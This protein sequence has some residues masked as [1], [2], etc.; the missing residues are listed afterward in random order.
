[1]RVANLLEPSL[2]VEVKTSDK[3]MDAPL[4]TIS[5]SGPKA[6]VSYTPNSSNS[7]GL[8]AA[9][10]NRNPF[11]IKYG[12]FAA[13]YGATKEQKAALD[14]GS[15]ATF[16]SPETGMRAAK[17]LLL[18]KNYR[19]LTVDQAMR[20]WSNNG[21]GGNIF[22]ELADRK[23]SD[24]SDAELTALQ[25]KQLIREDG[26]YARKLGY[27]AFGGPL[28]RIPKY[29]WGSYLSGLEAKSPGMLAMVGGLAGEGVDMIGDQQKIVAGRDAA[30]GALKGAGSGAALGTMLLPGIGTAVG[31]IAGAG[32]G[33]ASSLIKAKQKQKALAKSL[34]SEQ[35]LFSSMQE[36]G[37]SSAYAQLQPLRQYKYGGGFTPEYEVEKGEVVQGDAT[38]SNSK[39]LATELHEVTGYTHDQKNPKTGTTG[40]LGAGGDRA[41][42]NRLPT[43][44]GETFAE[45]AKKFS[46]YIRTGEKK[47]LSKNPLEKRTGQIILQKANQALDNLFEEQ[48]AMK[49]PTYAYGGTLPKLAKGGELEEKNKKLNELL[50][51][52]KL[53]TTP[54]AKAAVQSEIDSILSNEADL[55]PL[56]LPKTKTGATLD[57]NNTKKPKVG[58][59]VGGS[60]GIAL[61]RG[62]KDHPLKTV[63]DANTDNPKI[64]LPGNLPKVNLPTGTRDHELSLVEDDPEGLPKINLP[65][66]GKTATGGSKPTTN[67]AP[68]KKKEEVVS[69]VPDKAF[70]DLKRQEAEFAASKTPIAA[71]GNR[72]ATANKLKTQLDAR[73]TAIGVTPT[74]ATTAATTGN[75]FKFGDNALPIGLSAL[76]YLNTQKAINRSKTQVAANVT[77]APFYGYRDNSNLGRYNIDSA[78]NT[79]TQSRNVSDAQK[80]GYFAS[81]L[82]A[83]NQVN[84]GE[85]ERKM[86]YDINY[87][88]NKLRT[89]VQNN[90][91][92]NQ[93]REQTMTNEN[94][95]GAAS[96][97]NFTGLLGN[98]NTIIAEDKMNKLDLKKSKILADAYAKIGFK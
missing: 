58:T 84:S 49:I 94:A 83:S 70:T 23:I 82:N 95:K 6:P 73:G 37:S 8:S 45:K 88:T 55:P 11:N 56:S 35:E 34:K 29:G 25:R 62:T 97:A 31:A 92:I 30:S 68:K 86:N 42:T 24:L 39:E 16:D 81:S 15:F 26:K 28:A 63:R 9:E 36:S 7:K 93:A 75:G 44:T 69:E 79:A 96:A 32:I 50:K 67:Y 64:N 48:E 76:G 3:A 87:G 41:F 21:Y 12:D 47:Q 1:M 14:G 80:Q 4:P 66:R 59:G 85:A 38:L 71:L 46:K 91:M 60:D 65:T 52:Q 54:A 72:Y 33:A 18:G 13:R 20:R 10:R 19:N 98:V 77:Q 17:D 2:S 61:P 5:Y 89:D 74:A 57:L 40:V 53:A 27:F 78:L 51:K 43:S 22:P 90:Y